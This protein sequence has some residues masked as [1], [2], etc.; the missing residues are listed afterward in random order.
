MSTALLALLTL[1]CAYLLLCV[2]GLVILLAYC[3]WALVT[4]KDLS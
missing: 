1:P 4:G 3:A 2:P